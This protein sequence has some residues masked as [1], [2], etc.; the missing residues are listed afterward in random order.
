MT[1]KFIGDLSIQDAKVLVKLGS[2]AKHILE[3][4]AG[5]STQIFAQCKPKTLISVETDLH[6]VQLTEK[7]I[8]KLSD[9]TEPLFI[10]Y[11]RHP[12]QPFDLIFV[13]GVDNLRKEF[14]IDTW[15]LLT[16]G[17][18]MVF[19]DTRRFID[20]ANAAWIAQLH[21]NEI[22]KI[23]VNVDDSNMTVIYKKQHQPYVNWN[24]TE[25]KPLWAYGGLPNTEDQEL[26][27]L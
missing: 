24:Y 11:G 19:H 18:V 1:I 7:R 10:N 8:K 4:G 21:F 27:T 15:K 25:G 23:E 12:Q 22:S 3:F 14:A 13:D 20:F 5:G 17:G 26:W 6:W 9:I 2:Q 16:V